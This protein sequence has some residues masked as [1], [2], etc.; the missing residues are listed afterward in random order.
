[1]RFVIDVLQLLFD[2]LGIDLRRGNIGMTE[3]NQFVG[4][5]KKA[6]E[7]VNVDDFLDGRAAVPK[8]PS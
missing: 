1:M 2:K 3:A 6:R 5:V 8:D 4:F 7:M